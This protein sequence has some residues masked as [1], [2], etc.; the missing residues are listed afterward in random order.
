MDRIAIL[1][2]IHSN[3]FALEAVLSDAK[4]KNVKI[5]VNLGDIF[6]GPILPKKTYNLLQSVSMVTICGN[7]DRQIYESTEKE[8]RENSTMR[9]VRDELDDSIVNWMKCLPNKKILHDN[10]F[11]CH[12]APD[13]DLTYLLEDISHGIPQLRKDS[14]ILTMLSGIDCPIIICGHTHIP[15]V[16]TLSTDQIVINPGSVGLPAYKDDLPVKHCMENFTPHASYAILDKTWS[17]WNVE[18][19][20]VAYPFNKATQLAKERGREDWAFYLQTGRVDSP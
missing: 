8:L 9:L 19:I 20:K 7:Q 17:G 6:Y 1:S 14:E 10:I 16:V 3:A 15:R 18:L 4:K 5:F 12:G 2:D 13:D 11:L